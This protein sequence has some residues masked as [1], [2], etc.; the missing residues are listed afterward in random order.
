MSLLECRDFEVHLKRCCPGR[1]AHAAAR[2]TLDE[3][4]QSPMAPL[5][6][7]G[8]TTQGKENRDVEN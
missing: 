7:D 8:R 5:N 4:K 2:E 3:M 1:L 6:G